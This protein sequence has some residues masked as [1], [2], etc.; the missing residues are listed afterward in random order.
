MKD[1]D[2]LQCEHLC[3]TK[4][5][6]KKQ[7]LQE[8]ENLIFHGK[9]WT[10]IA[11]QSINHISRLVTTPP[12]SSSDILEFGCARLIGWICLA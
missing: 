6:N 4:E 2:L 8:K 5:W 3:S 10:I 9:K 12:R 1:N 7:N 11:Q